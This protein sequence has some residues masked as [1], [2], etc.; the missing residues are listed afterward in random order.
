[1]PR[2]ETL[3]LDSAGRAGEEVAGNVTGIKTHSIL[4][5]QFPGMRCVFACQHCCVPAVWPWVNRLPSTLAHL[6]VLGFRN[7]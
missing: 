3:R 6:A 7:K 5:P 1:M 4:E 2:D